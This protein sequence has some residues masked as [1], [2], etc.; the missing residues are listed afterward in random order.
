MMM[1]MR[2]IVYDSG[3]GIAIVIMMITKKMNNYEMMIMITW[4][5]DDDG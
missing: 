5:H 3:Y 4:K 2:I 1:M